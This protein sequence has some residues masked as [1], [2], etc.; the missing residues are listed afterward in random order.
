M[1]KINYTYL[2]EELNDN[3]E[4]KKQDIEEKWDMDDIELE[5]EC[6]RRYCTR[7]PDKLCDSCSKILNK[8]KD[9]YKILVGS[10]IE[11]FNKLLEYNHEH[12]NDTT[13]Q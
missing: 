8:Y 9:L 10:S 2:V 13:I 11:S 7:H 3:C 12:K 4:N 6:H 1:I 5:H